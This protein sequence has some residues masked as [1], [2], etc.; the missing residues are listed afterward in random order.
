M[1]SHGYPLTAGT[2]TTG[3]SADRRAVLSRRIRFLVAATISYNVIEGV[4]AITA[5]RQA[6][7]AALIGFGLDSVVEVLSAAVVA[8]QFAAKD[9]E[10]REKAALRFIAFAFFALAAFV[11]TDSVR[12]LLGAGEPGHSTTGLILAGLS[13]LVM[14]ALALTQ[15]RTGVELGSRSAVA[16]SRQTLICAWLS[17]VLLVGLGLNSVLGWS[18]ADPLAALVI[19]G[20]AVREGLE[21]WRGDACVSGGHHEDVDDCCDDAATPSRRSR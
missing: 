16:D 10:D 8:W 21:A 15:R 17:V 13:L 6:S 3:V 12:T 7:S 5:G 20:W 11:T 2:P 18:W 14:P 4:V 19:A 1:T 9:P